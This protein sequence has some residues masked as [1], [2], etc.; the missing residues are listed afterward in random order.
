MSSYDDRVMRNTRPKWLKIKLQSGKDYAAVA[1]LVEQNRLHTICESGQCPNRMECWERR[2]AT[3]MIL[4]NICTRS[5]RFCATATGRPLPADPDEPR[6]VA[7]SIAIMGLRY[8]VI[9]SVDRDDL[10][11]GGASMWAL[12]V[13]AIREK[14]PETKIELLIPDFGGNAELVDVVLA[15][16][17]DV[18]GHNIE[19]IERLTPEVRSAASYRRSLAVLRHI[20]DSGTLTK[21]GLMLGLGETESEVLQTLRD[22]REAGVDIVTIG[23]YLQPTA[24][25]LPVSEY[26][27][28]EKFEYY[29]KLAWDMGFKLV[30]SAPL[31]RSSYMAEQA[32]TLV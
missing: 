18:V 5:C 32:I 7:D 14:N 15:A 26:V 22:L 21:S 11:D 1:K 13:R 17:A 9:T 3:F 20:S 29:G 31:V 25:H 24:K 12:T 19:T 8:A 6:R 28:P 2:T 4:G 30:A 10:S 16:D 27:I 23:Q